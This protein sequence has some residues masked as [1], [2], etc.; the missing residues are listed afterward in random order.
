[1]L[2]QLRAERIVVEELA[3]GWTEEDWERRRKNDPGKLAIA[4]RLKKET[5]LSINRIAE[6]VR[7][8]SSNNANAN[9]HAWMQ[10]TKQRQRDSKKNE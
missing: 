8:G 6:R 7:L 4:A 10:Q 9:L 5:I 2:R 3:P 1:M